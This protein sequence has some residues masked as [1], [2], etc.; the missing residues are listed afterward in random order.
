LVGELVAVGAGDAFDEPVGAQP[1]QVFST[2]GLLCELAHATPDHL[3]VMCQ[4]PGHNHPAHRPHHRRARPR[5]T[6][7]P[8]ATPHPRHPHRTH[9]AP[10]HPSTTPH[11]HPAR[12]TTSHPPTP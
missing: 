12:R 8:G 4:Q 2:A 5:C 11:R 10:R 3:E 1:S 9:S 6:T 7:G